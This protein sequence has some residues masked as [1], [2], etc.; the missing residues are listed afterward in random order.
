MSV[1][2]RRRQA[3]NRRQWIGDLRERWDLRLGRIPADAT[4]VAICPCG[5][6]AWTTGESTPEDQQWFDDFD[7]AHA[8]CEVSS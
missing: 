5:A 8:D 3:I 1:T 2:K 7:Y 6:R 4:A